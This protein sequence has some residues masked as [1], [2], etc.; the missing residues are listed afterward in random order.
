MAAWIRDLAAKRQ[1]F[2]TK[3]A[4]SR[5]A[6]A[7]FVRSVGSGESGRLPCVSITRKFADQRLCR[8]KMAKADLVV[9]RLDT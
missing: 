6:G 8:P 3:L 1:A 2:R 9:W 7:Y 4:H 5:G